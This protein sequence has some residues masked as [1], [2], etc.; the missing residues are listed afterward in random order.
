MVDSIIFEN[1]HLVLPIV[2]IGVFL[3]LVFLWK[4][5]GKS[6]KQFLINSLVGFLALTSLLLIALKPVVLSKS[7]PL[8]IALLT[9]GYRESS[10]D[11]LKK[12]NKKL[13][14]IQYS[15]GENLFNSEEK[16]TNAYVLG[17]GIAAYDLWQLDNIP[18]IYISGKNISGITKLKYNSSPYVGESISVKGLYSKPKK[19]N[20]L[21]LVNP[22]GKNLDSISFS[23]TNDQKFQLS[24]KAKI[25]G[26]FVY[27][28]VEKD[29]LDTIVKNNSLPISVKKREFLKVLIINSFPTFETKYLKNF[30][31]EKKHKVVV[32]NQIS[33]DRFKYEFFNTVKERIS[34]SNKSLETFDLLIID[35]KSFLSL[36]KNQR[37]IL[38]SAIENKGLGVFIQPDKN[39][40][41]TRNSISNFKFL[42]NKQNTFTNRLN[43]SITKYNYVFRND[44]SSE[45]IH[46]QNNKIYSAYKYLGEGK[47][48]TSVA[49]ET[50]HLVLSGKL[51]SY[52]QFWTDIINSISK[53]ELQIIKWGN[54][55]KISFKDEPFYFE[56]QTNY[57]NPEVTLDYNRVLLNQNVNNPIFWRGKVYPNSTGWHLLKIKND[58][59]NALSFYTFKDNEY[60]ALNHFETKR[61]NKQVLN[62]THD[63]SNGLNHKKDVNL[64]WFYLFFLLCIGYLW[65]E[66]KL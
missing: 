53:K 62:K 37:S 50:Y 42:S 2:L 51:N 8:T 28:L 33:K 64:F 47:I 7:K 27:S 54:T 20:R 55:Q 32:R 25:S 12:L 16:P 61:K 10:L 15:K 4:E 63:L 5:W 57:I 13:K 6:R 43:Q 48:G 45:P 11:S 18:C 30:L 58:S 35:N 52:Q 3:F 38:K 60:K 65:L 40:F 26:N 1:K 9:E 19:K 39:L 21:F 66:P 29:S 31:T 17:H 23:N 59:T 34:F 46:Q 41:T 56:L 14:V 36:R 22:N 44:N 49:S 24:I